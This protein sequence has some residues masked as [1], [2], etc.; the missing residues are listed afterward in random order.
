MTTNVNE[1]GPFDD[2]ISVRE[3][4]KLLHVSESTIWRWVNKDL[5]AAHKVGPK[6]VCLRKRDVESMVKPAL[7]TPARL[8]ERELRK[9][10]T[11]INPN[12]DPTLSAEELL[13]QVQALEDEFVAEHGDVL[14]PE[15]WI[16]IN[17]AR[18]GRS[19]EMDEW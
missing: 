2:L 5:I 12:R 11:P 14:L 1:S 19:R 13:A 3:A 18:D 4:A 16:D 6:L 17:E 8:D 15:S 9:Y 10:L 7:K